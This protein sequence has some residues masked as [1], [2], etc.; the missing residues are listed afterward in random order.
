MRR[1][2]FVALACAFMTAAALAAAAQTP[3]KAAAVAGKWTVSLE[4]ES[5]TA[6]SA[7]EFKQDGE[8]L[9]GTYTSTRYGATPLQGTIKDRAIEFTFKLN[10]DGTDV[11]MAFK[12]EVA[13]DGQTMKGRMSI[14]EMG[15]GTWTA[16]KEK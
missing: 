1:T 14:A 15:D 2:G 8:K 4:T 9:T 7:L 6:T 13:A 11:P 3:A 12:G 10:A 16:K 5:F